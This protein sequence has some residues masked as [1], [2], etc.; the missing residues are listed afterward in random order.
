MSEPFE[1]IEKGLLEAIA[2]AEE[3][4]KAGR[5]YTPEEA[6]AK[7]RK[8]LGVTVHEPSKSL[9]NNSRQAQW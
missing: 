5:T 8:E 3:D 1:S 7:L 6:M 2:Y 4:I 9:W